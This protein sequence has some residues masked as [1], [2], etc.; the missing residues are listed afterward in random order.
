MSEHEETKQISRRQFLK[1]AGIVVGGTAVGSSF[2][3]AACKGD[4]EEVTKTVT[5]TT[6][7]AKFKCPYD[8]QEFDTY[9]E[10]QAHVEAAH[11]EGDPITFTKF[12]SP[13]DG[14]EFDSLD[15]LK[16][17][18]DANFMTAGIPGVVSFVVNGNPVT[19]KVEDYW[20]LDFVLRDRLA[21]YG[22]KVGCGVGQCG[23]CTVL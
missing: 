4:A 19:L 5:V 3:L 9:A 15:A 13:Y 10:L 22:T 17:H 11:K 1:N 14:A 8:G 23:A 21:L 2:I 20:T 6:A 18:L 12:V 16:A 7:T